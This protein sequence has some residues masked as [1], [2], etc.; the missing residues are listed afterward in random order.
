[1]P[2]KSTPNIDFMLKTAKDYID[3]KGNPLDFELDYGY[4]LE[5]R[6]DAMAREDDKLA[7]LIYERL[8]REGSDYADNETTEK[9]RRRIKRQ[10]DYVI[11]VRNN[12]F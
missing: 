1:M 3:G 10:Y 7:N 4:E 11:D 8:V 9:L 12:S 2:R 5:K 6:Y